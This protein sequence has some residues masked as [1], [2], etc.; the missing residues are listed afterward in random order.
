MLII[1]K[2]CVPLRTTKLEPAQFSDDASLGIT[3]AL[4][5][6]TQTDDEVRTSSKLIDLITG[7]TIRTILPQEPYENIESWLSPDGQYTLESHFTMNRNQPLLR[8]NTARTGEDFMKLS[9]EAMFPGDHH[10]LMMVTR[11]Y[12][13]PNN[14]HLGICLNTDQAR[15]YEPSILYNRTTSEHIPCTQNSLSPFVFNHDGSQ[16]L[17]KADNEDEPDSNEHADAIHVYTLPQK[18][19]K[20][21]TLPKEYAFHKAIFSADGSI[22]TVAALQQQNMHFFNFYK[23]QDG[24]SKP[25]QL[26]TTIPHATKYRLSGTNTFQD[27]CFTPTALLL[28]TAA[29]QTATMRD[30]ATGKNLATIDTEA[31]IRSALFSGNRS[32]VMLHDTRNNLTVYDMHQFKLTEQA[33][34]EKTP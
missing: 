1:Q 5:V 33:K 20:N 27:I 25:E 19:M 12:A 16:V 22:I 4:T 2:S 18:T 9:F 3:N 17:Q 34:K 11:A 7:E 32:K 21:L 10:S 8:M 24:Y 29:Q 30:I 6:L 28:L 13:S 14:S 15:L 26:T 31:P 23:T